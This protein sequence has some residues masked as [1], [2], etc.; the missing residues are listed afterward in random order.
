MNNI[1][2]DGH[3]ANKE[4]LID[5]RESLKEDELVQDMS[6][7]FQALSEPNRLKIVH[8][9]QQKELCVHDLS[10]ILDM[11]QSSVSHH[12]RVLRD[13]K[14]VKFKKSGK[15]V[16]YSVDDDCVKMI[17]NNGFNHVNYHG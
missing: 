1:T 14:L 10:K 4:E 17:Y 16:I 15:M 7:M 12:L 6:S 5:L 8:I 13:N 9:L 2:T 11:S 3:L